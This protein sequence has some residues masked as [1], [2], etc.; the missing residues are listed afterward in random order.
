M[1][2]KSTTRQKPSVRTTVS[3]PKDD[4]VELEA[5]AERQKVSVAWIVRRAVEEYLERQ[6][7]L[8]RQTK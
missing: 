6:R 1:S 7:P 8:L 2:I 4:Y 5:M 3:V